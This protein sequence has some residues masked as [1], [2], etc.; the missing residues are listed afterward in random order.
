MSDK[1]YDFAMTHYKLVRDDF[2]ADK[3]KYVVYI[4]SF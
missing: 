2:K 4:R 3:V 1:D